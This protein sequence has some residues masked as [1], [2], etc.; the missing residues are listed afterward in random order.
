[1]GEALDE[2]GDEAK[3]MRGRIRDIAVALQSGILPSN[4]HRLPL[5]AIYSYYSPA[6]AL[7]IPTHQADGK[8]Y[9]QIWS[10]TE[11]SFSSLADF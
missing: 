9:Y 2:C 11:R 10:A 7:F 3:E 8:V 1:M 4:Q 6:T 5:S